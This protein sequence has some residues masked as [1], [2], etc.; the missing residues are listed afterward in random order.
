MF[1]DLSDAAVVAAIEETTRAEAIAA[2]RRSALVAELASRRRVDADDEERQRWVVDPWA[3]TAAEISAAMGIS[4]RAA[5]TQM[6]IALAL[7]DR[8]PKV[9]ALYA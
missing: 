8:L 6:C 3:A 1:G 2:A 9:A 5:S 4:P 7:R